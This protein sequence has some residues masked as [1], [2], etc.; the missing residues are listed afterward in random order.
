[1]TIK[2]APPIVCRGG[3]DTESP[4]L[5]LPSG[6]L[7]FCT[8]FESAQGGGYRRID[9]YQAYDGG[10][11]KAEVPGQGSI[12]GINY[13]N[14]KVQAFRNAAGG[15]TAVMYESSTGGWSSKKTGLTPSGQYEFANYNFAGGIA[16]KKMYGCSGV[17]LGFSWDGTNWVDLPTGSVPD[18][19]EHIAAHKNHLFYSF[20]A[21]LQNSG[22]GDPTSWTLRS[23]AADI[24][25]GEQINGL[26]SYRGDTLAVYAQSKT[27]ML[28]GTG[29]TTWA[30]KTLSDKGGAESRTQVELAGDAYA[31]SKNGLVSLN[32][33][34]NY[35]DF[36]T[37]IISKRIKRV[38]PGRQ[39]LFSLAFRV[40]QQIRMYFDDQSVITAT[41]LDGD[42]GK[43]VEFTRQILDHQ[44]TCGVVGIDASGNEVAFAGASDG[45]VYQLDTGTSFAGAAITSTLR[46][47][48]MYLNGISLRK[49]IHKVRLELDAPSAF[50]F[51][52]GIDFNYG[53][54]TPA[55]S[56]DRTAT[57]GGALYSDGAYA[58]AVYGGGL[59]GFCDINTTGVGQNISLLLSHTSATD[60]P[61]TLNAAIV[62]YSIRGRQK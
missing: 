28:Y 44:F 3:L 13:Y 12:L 18:T 15:A 14:Y 53:T 19:P 45:F 23:G 59:V 7:I 22:I 8:N 57:A 58:T 30:L 61:W 49:R 42:N 39:A 37:A 62:D 38:F 16:S 50:T 27:N 46:L 31:V 55:N 21:S 60:S 24:G 35:G 25:M 36:F 43:V 17:H 9:G 33:T 40:K 5:S 4:P 2:T 51:N 41:I 54:I 56:L 26:Q 52:F 47:P 32:S 1:M 29:S 10:T 48:F 6:A 34:Q 11:T 20:G